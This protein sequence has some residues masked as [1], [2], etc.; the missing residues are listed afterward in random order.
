MRCQTTPQVRTNYDRMG[1]IESLGAIIAAM[2]QG[3]GVNP[4]G[5]SS[6]SLDHI[7]GIKSPPLPNGFISEYAQ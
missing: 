7:C 6:N 4:G 1:Y 2:R 5:E 3:G